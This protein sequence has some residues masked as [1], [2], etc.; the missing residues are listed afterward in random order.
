MV[1]LLYHIR[2]QMVCCCTLMRSLMLLLS[3]LTSAW[4]TNV[5]IWIWLVTGSLGASVDCVILSELYLGSM[6]LR[7]SDS[8]SPVMILAFGAVLVLH[9]CGFTVLVSRMLKNYSSLFSLVVIS[10]KESTFCCA[11][12]SHLSLKYSIRNL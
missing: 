5:P 6:F 9:R 10:R 1:C 7:C 8:K 2:Q 3:M 12:G 4:F 11:W